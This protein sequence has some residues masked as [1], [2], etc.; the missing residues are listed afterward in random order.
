LLCHANAALKA[1][2]RPEAVFQLYVASRATCYD[3]ADA[4]VTYLHD[5]LHNDTFATE[6]A[7]TRAALAYLAGNWPRAF[8]FGD[9]VTAIASEGIEVDGED[10]HILA[11][12][13]LRAYSY[14][15][16]LVSLHSYAPPVATVLQERPIAS[17][18]ARLQGSRWREVTNLYHEQVALNE[19]ELAVL[20]LLD[21]THDRAMLREA[22]GVS[23]G[24]DG[25]LDAALEQI[26]RSALLV[27]SQGPEAQ[28]VLEDR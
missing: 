24:D 26:R 9:M 16:E 11:S 8:A 4:G 25:A 6:H 15:K 12:N 28:Q 1:E 21:G 3:D 2:V 5:A 27:V 20:A 14:R 10:L 18:V 13:L 22:L 19:R 23:T 7:P 17:P